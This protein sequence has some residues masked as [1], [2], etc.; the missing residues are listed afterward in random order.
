MKTKEGDG[1]KRG[2]G[3]ENFGGDAQHGEWRE[4]GLRMK[5]DAICSAG[6]KM[7]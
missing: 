5:T 2:D 1:V 3:T 4:R 7:R 6:D